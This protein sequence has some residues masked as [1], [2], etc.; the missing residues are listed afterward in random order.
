MAVYPTLLLMHFIQ[1]SLILLWL[2]RYRLN[3]CQYQRRF[4]WICHCRY[5]SR[6]FLT[7]MLRLKS[8]DTQS[9]GTAAETAHGEDI[10]KYAED[11]MCRMLFLK[12][13]MQSRRHSH[14]ETHGRLYDISR[15]MSDR[16]RSWLDILIDADS[17]LSP[18]RNQIHG[19][20]VNLNDYDWLVIIDYWL[21]ISG[22][23]FSN[24]REQ[25]S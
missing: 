22:T 14:A 21:L 24:H 23:S 15:Y 16:P 6:S 13:E 19:F 2:Q 5:E 12:V 25:T 4:S 9:G 10:L 8:F 1:N 18:W 17:E 11:E 3:Q 20:S 7:L